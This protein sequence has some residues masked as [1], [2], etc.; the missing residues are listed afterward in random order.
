[1]NYVANKKV[2]TFFGLIIKLLIY[3]LIFMNKIQ[4]LMKK[5]R[6]NE[7]LFEQ[8]IT[9]NSDVELIRIA[10]EAGIFL[11]VEE[12]N[13]YSENS[14]NSDVLNENELNMI[15]GGVAGENGSCGSTWPC[16]LNI[17]FGLDCSSCGY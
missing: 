11:S 13:C 15:S 8:I 1:M 7:D 5:A 4:L 6:K 16:Y 3:G 12:I 2:K 10:S 17:N 9:V 14:N